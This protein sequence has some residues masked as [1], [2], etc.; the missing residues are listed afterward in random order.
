MAT[1]PKITIKTAS[2]E[3]IK[4]ANVVETVVVGEMTIGLKKPNV[5]RQYQIVEVVGNSAKNETYMGMVMPLLWVVEINGEDQPYISTKRE[6]EALISRLGDE[7]IG[8]IMG[9]LNTKAIAA[10]S[11]ESIKN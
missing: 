9:H 2:E 6:L 1:Q 7:G 10:E 3:I 11:D 4:A 8:A 5:L